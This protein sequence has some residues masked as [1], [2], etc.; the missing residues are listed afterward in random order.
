MEC[1]IKKPTHPHRVYS[2]FKGNHS[3]PVTFWSIS[4][5]KRLRYQHLYIKSIQ[6]Q[7]STMKMRSK[8]IHQSSSINPRSNQKC[9]SCLTRLNYSKPTPNKMI[10]SCS[11]NIK[12]KMWSWSQLRKPQMVTKR[13]W[14]YS[15]HCLWKIAKMEAHWCVAMLNWT[16]S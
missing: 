6:E 3:R 15:Y 4:I 7:T 5:T 11:S 12:T 16:K 8:I 10:N 13:M 1:S 2:N 9:R 14:S